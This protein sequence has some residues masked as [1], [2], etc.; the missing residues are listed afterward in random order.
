MTYQNTLG[1]ETQKLL[2]LSQEAYLMGEID[3]INLLEAQNM[4]LDNQEIYLSA[5]RDYYIYLIEL[6]KFTEQ[7]LVY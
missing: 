1:N 6:E 4:F 7:K 3:L 5:L 2:D